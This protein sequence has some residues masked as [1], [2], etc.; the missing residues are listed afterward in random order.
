MNKKT[1]VVIVSIL[2]IIVGI[3]YL[4]PGFSHILTYN[5]H[6]KTAQVKHAILFFVLA[7][8]AI[9]FGRIIVN[10]T[11]SSVDIGNTENSGGEKD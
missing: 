8:I 11:S 5:N 7:A 10:R 9:I 3:Y 2:F 6:P 4:I 1:I